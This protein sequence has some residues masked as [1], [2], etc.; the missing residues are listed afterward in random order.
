MAQRYEA[1]DGL[2]GLA[3]TSVVLI[4][5][6]WPNHVTATHAAQHVYSFV[7]LF[8]VLSGFILT[9]VYRQSISSKDQLRRFLILRIFRIY[10]LHAAVL[11]VMLVIELLKWLVTVNGVVVANSLPFYGSR[12]PGSFLGHLFLLQGTGLVEPS[13]NGPSW[14]IGCEEIAYILFG[15]MTLGGVLERRMLVPTAILASALAYGLGLELHGNLGATFDFGLLRCLGGF[16]IGV[17]VAV[18]VSKDYVALR[19]GK[20]SDFTLS[21]ATL[22]LTGCAALLLCWI[23]GYLDVLIVPVFAVLVLFLQLDRGV[24]AQVLRSRI[25][26]FLGLVSYSIYM[27]NYPLLMSTESVF[28]RTL[29]IDKW[30]G[31]VLL[32]ATLLIVVL[33]AWATFEW[34][35]SPG[36]AFGRRL[37][38]LGDRRRFAGNSVGLAAPRERHA[39]D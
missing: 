7:D 4:H 20:L 30:T 37:A 16:L 14:S 3:A 32:G 25:F 1:L 38:R 22:A 21:A 11:C 8:F 29:N 31:D 10:P 18:L 26:A 35:E 15:A 39:L 28:K 17:C 12:S 5:V 33:V 34:I 13:W 6:P 19:L 9:V 36:R 27:I 24:V 23:D 2:R